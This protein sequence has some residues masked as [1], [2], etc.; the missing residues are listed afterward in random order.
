M[1]LSVLGTSA[2]VWPNIPA[3]DDDDDDDECETVGGMLWG[4]G[5]L[6]ENLTQSFYVHKIS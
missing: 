6:A 1:R 3:P 2:T 4:G 5:V